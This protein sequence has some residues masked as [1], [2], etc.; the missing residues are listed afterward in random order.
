MRAGYAARDALSEKCLG[1]TVELQLEEF[2]KYG[3][4]LC[5]VLVDGENL[6]DWMLAEG[7]GVPYHGGTKQDIDW[8]TYRENHLAK[9]E[10]TEDNAAEAGDEAGDVAEE[11]EKL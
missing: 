5:E 10:Q 9:K 7:Y 11:L 8:A 6:N 4:L 2:D 3:R 1:K